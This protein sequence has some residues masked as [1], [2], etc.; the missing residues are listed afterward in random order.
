MWE[1]ILD[2]NH[3]QFP[4]QSRLSQRNSC[5]TIVK[6]QFPSYENNFGTKLIKCS[7]LCSKYEKF[8]TETS[9]IMNVKIESKL[10]EY[11]FHYFFFCET[12]FIFRTVPFDCVFLH[13]PSHFTFHIPFENNSNKKSCLAKQFVHRKKMRSSPGS[14]TTVYPKIEPNCPET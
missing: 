8:A 13:S 14:T 11:S 10:R 9:K 7:H 3:R 6:F 5:K 1:S 2:L 4:I 12:L